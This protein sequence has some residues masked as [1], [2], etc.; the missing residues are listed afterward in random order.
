MAAIRNF[1]FV[2][3][4]PLEAGRARLEGNQNAGERLVA[5]KAGASLGPLKGV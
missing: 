2:L 1:P 3:V 4:F 5:W